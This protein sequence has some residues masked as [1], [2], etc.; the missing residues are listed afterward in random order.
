MRPARLAEQL[1]GARGACIGT[2]ALAG[3]L[4]CL[5]FAGGAD[6]AQVC[7]PDGSSPS[8]F[9]ID[10]SLAVTSTAAAAPFDLDASVANTSPALTTDTSTWLNTAAIRLTAAT[11]TPPTITRSD[12]LANG[13]QLAGGT[14]CNPPDYSTCAGGHGTLVANITSCCGSANGQNGAFGIAKIVNVN[15]PGAGNFVHYRATI[16]DCVTPAFSPSQCFQGADTT[17]DI[18]IAD[19]PSG[20]PPPLEVTL[21]TRGSQSI[22][23]GAFSGNVDYSLSSFTLHLEGSS[24]QVDGGAPL[25]APQTIFALPS[26]C[27]TIAGAATFVSGDSRTISVPQSF[28]VTGCQ[29]QPAN[30]STKTSVTG[31]AKKKKVSVKGSVAPVSAGGKV[32]LRLLRKKGKRYLSVASR[33]TS[34]GAGV[35]RASFGNPRG[36]RKCE[37][38]ATYTGD[39]LHDGSKDESR[40]KC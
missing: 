11:A 40:F 24:D 5:V 38:V 15:P 27:G 20:A 10:Y 14:P 17:Q 29:E 19:T 36:A 25:A 8:R 3:V 16:Q 23:F 12:E 35:F 9:C 28:P 34:L 21:V 37:V 13:L 4:A 30:R 39:A 32:S 33:S 6:A 2:A 18:V 1:H 31:K 22:S 7:N 26:T